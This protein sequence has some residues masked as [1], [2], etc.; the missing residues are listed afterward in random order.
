MEKLMTVGD[1]ADLFGCSSRTINKLKDSGELS[2]I[3]LGKLIRFRPTDVD[4]F[5]HRQSDQQNPNDREDV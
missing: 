2:H 1:V 3:R 4:A 5:L